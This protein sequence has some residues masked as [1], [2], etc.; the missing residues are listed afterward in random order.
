[1]SNGQG[2]YD[3]AI[4]ESKQCGM[5]YWLE[6]HL[7]TNLQT[8]IDLRGKQV[9]TPALFQ[10]TPTFNGWHLTNRYAGSNRRRNESPQIL[11][12][13]LIFRVALMEI[14]YGVVGLHRVE[15]RYR[16]WWSLPQWQRGSEWKLSWWNWYLRPWRRSSY[17]LLHVCEEK[18]TSLFWW[19]RRNGCSDSIDGFHFMVQ[20]IRNIPMK[21][22]MGYDVSNLVFWPSCYMRLYTGQDQQLWRQMMV[23]SYGQPFMT[24]SW[25]CEKFDFV[26]THPA[27]IYLA[28]DVNLYHS[29]D[30]GNTWLNW[31]YLRFSIGFVALCRVRHRFQHALI[32]SLLTMEVDKEF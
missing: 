28:T 22:I 13:P 11:A 29:T 4:R 18:D 2:Y 24:S 15:W 26:W 9:A 6:Q 21:I 1:M 14:W 3:L 7:C 12:I 8:G 5:K 23:V 16:R 30:T 27:N 19:C 31:H 25:A 20:F 10:F 32:S 17:W